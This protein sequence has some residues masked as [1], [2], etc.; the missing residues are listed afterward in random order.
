MPRTMESPRP[1]PSP[2]ASLR[3]RDLEEIVEHSA[4]AI[5]LATHGA[6]VALHLVGSLHDA[7]AQRLDHRPDAGERRAQVV[8][9]RGRQFATCP[10]ELLAV[11]FGRF[12]PLGETI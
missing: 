10:V 2:E 4:Q 5:D 11:A 7:V 9:E 12:E 8:R 3:L 6:Q 1:A